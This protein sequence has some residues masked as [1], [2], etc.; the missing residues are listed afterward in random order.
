MSEHRGSAGE[1]HA[2]EEQAE[3]PTLLDTIMR[4]QGRGGRA[5]TVLVI[6]GL[7]GSLLGG[8]GVL[9]TL[10]E[11]WQLSPRSP[12]TTSIDS[13]CGSLSGTHYT[14]EVEGE[15]FTCGGSDTKCGG[16]ASVAIAYDPEDPSQCR[17]A[18]NVDRLSDYELQVLML[19]LAFVSVGLAGGTYIWSE[20]LRRAEIVDSK[21]ARAHRRLQLRRL[22]GLALGAAF[23]LVNAFGILF[24][25]NL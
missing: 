11:P 4:H 15:Q 12:Q 21:P 6:V 5:A 8:S 25:L 19:A 3:P 18:A 1:E 13:E 23:C 22:S 2:G 17:V 10:K 20:H 7:I 16:G 14:I 9:V 24:L